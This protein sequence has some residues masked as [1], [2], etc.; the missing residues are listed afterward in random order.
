MCTLVKERGKQSSD[1]S[2]GSHK[3]CTALLSILLHFFRFLFYKNDL[4]LALFRYADKES[5][6]KL[7]IDLIKRDLKGE[8]SASKAS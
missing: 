3:S 7:N 8:D 6:G 1:G 5:D 2:T 4:L